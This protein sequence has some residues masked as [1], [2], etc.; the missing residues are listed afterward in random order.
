MKIKIFIATSFILFVI[1]VMGFGFW[2]VAS[3]AEKAASPELIARGKELFTS[4]K[5]LG[6]KYACILCHQKEKVIKRSEIL[7]A[8]D[9]LPDM[10]NK[11]L[12]EKAKGAK[13]L[14]KNSAEMKALA[15]YILYEHSQ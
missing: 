10:I 9:S 13:P 8:G 2:A 11:Y 7:K 14:D 12:L 15:A 6:T 1:G 3:E 4:T 5:S